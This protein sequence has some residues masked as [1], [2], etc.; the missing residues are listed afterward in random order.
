MCI[1]DS[2]QDYVDAF[3][4]MGGGPGIEGYVQKQT[5]IDIIEK[6]FQL[7]FDMAEFLE[8]ISS[9][10]DNLDFRLFCQLFEGSRDESRSATSRQSLLS[11]F[12]RRGGRNQ[13]FH[14]RYKDFIKFCE[15]MDNNDN[16][17]SP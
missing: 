17:L 15:K 1:R 7:A 10:Q 14:V 3:I 8:E 13:S 12:S 5:I 16:Q 11:A 6:E 9:N 2:N 4:A